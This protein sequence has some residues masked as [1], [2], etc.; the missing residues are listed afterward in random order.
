M[1]QS[2]DVEAMEM[3]YEMESLANFPMH[4]PAGSPVVVVVPFASDVVAGGVR[5]L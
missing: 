3:M 5:V 1:K 2:R 4:E